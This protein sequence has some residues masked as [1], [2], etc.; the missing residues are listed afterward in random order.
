MAS[1]YAHCVK[2]CSTIRKG[3]EM[4]VR[5]AKRGGK[6][7]YIKAR[8]KTRQSAGGNCVKIVRRTQ[9]PPFFYDKETPVGFFHASFLVSPNTKV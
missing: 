8:G 7:G 9:K 1:Q 5:A 3:D 2:Y 6:S 4:T